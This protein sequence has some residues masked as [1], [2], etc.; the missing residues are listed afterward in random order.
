[1]PL[2]RIGCP[3]SVTCAALFVP[4]A[5][6][7]PTRLTAT[8]VFKRLLIANRGEIAVR[9]IRACRELGIAPVAV[10]SEADAHALH[11]RMA[12]AAFLIGPAPASDSYLASERIVDAALAARADA[13]H[14][15]YGFL[16]ENADFAQACLDAGLEFIGPPPKAMRA[17]GLKTEARKLMQ[18]VGVP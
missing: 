11:V 6:C 3:I 17:L 2:C 18:A 12:D 8:S 16:A 14:P 5:A 7:A 9:V 4:G 10:Y 1:M 15:G 13:V